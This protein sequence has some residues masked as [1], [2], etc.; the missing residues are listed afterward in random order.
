[1]EGGALNKNKNRVNDFEKTCLVI[2]SVFIFVTIPKKGKGNNIMKNK[3]FTEKERYQLEILLKKKIPIIQIAKD[4]DKSRTTI[5]NE[6]KRG[7]VKQ[8]DTHL[9]S[10]LVYKADVAQQISIYNQ[11][12]KGRQLK[13][14]SDYDFV[15]IFTDLILNKKYSPY[16]ALQIIKNDYPE[17][18]TK[19]SLSTAYNY[20]RSHVFMDISSNSLP[21]PRKR[22]IKREGKKRSVSLNNLCS[23]SISER[24]DLINNRSLPFNWEMDT[25]VSGKGG[26]CALLVLTERYSRFEI[27]RKINSK[28]SSEVKRVLDDLEFEYG[29]EKFRSVFRSFTCDNGVEFLDSEGI[30]TSIDGGVRSDLYY[31]HPYSSWERG[32]NENQN[33]LIRRWIPKGS[34]ISQFSDEFILYVQNWMNTLP[35]K[36]FNN[37]SSL[38]VFN[39]CL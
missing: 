24:S 30:A 2:D 10:Y 3:Y 9:K 23:K 27:I 21:S 22:Q 7:L 33:K 4:L 35:R 38:D 5:Y 28:T 1:M 39:S 13:L 36:L 11:S 26:S 12:A 6:I 34:D 20:I 25:V 19:I 32:S 14:G 29:S 17:I 18:K 37:L 16:S 31:C 8:I 15:K